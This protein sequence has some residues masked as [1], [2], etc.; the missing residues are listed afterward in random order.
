M[1]L[2][3]EKQ[4][5][6]IRGAREHNLKNIDLDIMRGK[7]TVIT[8]VSGSGKS[9]LAFDTILA[10]S[11]RRFFYT[12]S[13]Y[14]RQF[15]DLGT[16]PAVGQI[17]G[18]SPAIALSQSETQP[19]SRATVGTLTD[20]SELLGVLF[21]RFGERL[22]PIH[23]IS[24]DGVDIDVIIDLIFKSHEG[25]TIGIAAPV[26][27]KK[28]GVFRK[29]LTSFAEKGYV[30]ALIDSEIC[31]LDPLP[32]L[33]KD[34]KH[35]ISIIIDFIK[36]DNSKK[37]RLKRS[38]ETAISLGNEIGQCFVA[39]KNGTLTEDTL[40]SFS[41]SKGCP[42]C[43][44]SWPK[45]DSRHFSINSLGA[46]STCKG[47]G[48]LKLDEEETLTSVDIKS[49]KPCSSCHG[50][51]LKK[52]LEAITFYKHNPRTLS[53]MSIDDLCHLFKKIK[54]DKSISNPACQRILLEISDHL[55]RIQ[56]IGLGYLNLSRRVKSLSGGEGQRL[57]LSNVISENLRGVLY[58]LDEPSQGLSH[59]EIDFVWSNLESLKKSGN[60]II[61][62]D[63]DENFIRKADQIIDLGPEG[64]SQGGS[65]VAIFK[66]NEAAKYS[67]QSKTASY[68]S[69]TKEQSVQRKPKTKPRH[70]MEIEKPSLN[71]L[72]MP[73]I[74]IPTGALTVVTGPSGSGKSSLILGTL[75]PNLLAQLNGQS[76]QSLHC[77]R[78]K[79]P[80]S[81]DKLILID[82]KPIAKTS[83]S[84]PATYLDIFTDLRQLFAKLPEAQIAGLTARSFSLSVDDGRCKECKGK[85]MLSLSMKFLSDAKVQCP[86]CNGARYQPFVLD[87]QY[88]GHSLSDILAL[89]IEEVL[90]LFSSFRKI[91]KKLQP[92]VD[93]GLG[94]LILGQPSS[95][96]SGGE[97]QRLK[98]VPYLS[99]Q[100]S[101][102]SVLL[103]DEPTRGLHFEDVERLNTQLE[104]IRSMGS[105]V[106]VIEHHEAVI[107]KADWVLELG[108]GSGNEGGLIAKEFQPS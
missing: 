41:I 106:I 53:L 8:G 47:M 2:S 86:E 6:S 96:L 26:V 80:K 89:T 48:Y 63:H 19:S 85:G 56:S 43:G 37:A 5:I 107:N 62:V 68:L 87:V 42:Q 49:M 64:G 24:A 100:V 57:R 93:L 33:N 29:Q 77:S 34:L 54:A 104:R 51:G 45:L 50:S 21:A 94:Y 18:L 20:T 105:S 22:C 39:K 84:M 40:Q 9:S 82:R 60:T 90:D 73:S 70:W 97:A 98:L 11:Q 17:T 75:Y 103:L 46:C 67:K 99:K 31:D 27:Q 3:P 7:I 55:N 30:K 88:K 83:V 52:E 95:S 59:K 44:F 91:S 72:K 38:L 15:L 108:P 69:K 4:S 76:K 65:I 10:E 101:E 1:K 23:D 66:P 74:R 13:H 25:K 102:S 81:L 92:A 16:R 71:N 79:G 28:K 78:F 61:I 35:D 14:T 32:E 58:I 12:L 36:V